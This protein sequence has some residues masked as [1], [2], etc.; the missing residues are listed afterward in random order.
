[1][2][3]IRANTYESLRALGR[4]D[5]RSLLFENERDFHDDLV[6]GDSIS[7]NLNFLFLDPGTPHISQR[8]CRPLNTL[9]HSIFEDL[10]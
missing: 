5:L 9:L 3:W 1:M 8:G 6:S 7:F 2:G 4:D 10:L